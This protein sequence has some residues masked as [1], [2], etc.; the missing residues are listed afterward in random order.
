MIRLQV[1]SSHSFFIFANYI[2]TTNHVGHVVIKTTNSSWH[3]CFKNKICVCFVYVLD[4][5]QSILFPSSNLAIILVQVKVD[6]K[7]LAYWW[8]VVPLAQVYW[9]S[10]NVPYGKPSYFFQILMNFRRKT[11]ALNFKTFIWLV[12][13]LSKKYITLVVMKHVLLAPFSL[14][15]P[16]SKKKFLY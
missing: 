2:F 15:V 10:C 1:V 6:T 8:D 5:T 16:K 3:L 12:W 9:T 7:W 14:N 4:N 11:I 13:K